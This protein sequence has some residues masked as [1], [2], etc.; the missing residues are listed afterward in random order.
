MKL[1]FSFF[2]LFLA[3]SCIP[4]AMKPN[5]EDYKIMNGKKFKRDLPNQNSFIF[6]DPKKANEFYTYINVKFNKEHQEVGFNNQIEVNGITYYMTFYEAER[7]AKTI[8]LL[9]IVT[10]AVLKSKNIT[11]GDT[12]GNS[13]TSR[14][15]QWYLIITVNDNNLKDAL[16]NLNPNRADLIKFLRDMKHEYLSTANYQE[17]YFKNPPIKK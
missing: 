11:N 3:T 13:Y 1:F 16:S 12:F 7:K 15:G 9:P 17:I 6:E 10:D 2:A 8:N 5:V 4:V 14:V